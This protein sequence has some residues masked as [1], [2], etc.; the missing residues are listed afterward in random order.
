[1]DLREGIGRA[2]LLLIQEEECWL[3]ALQNKNTKYEKT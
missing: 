3:I 1:M 2:S